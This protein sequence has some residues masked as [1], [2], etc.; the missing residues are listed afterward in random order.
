MFTHENEINEKKVLTE[1]NAMDD[2][3]VQFS[4]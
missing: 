1:K 4:L 2:L 3:K